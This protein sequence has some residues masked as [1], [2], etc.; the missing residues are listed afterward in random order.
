MIKQGKRASVITVEPFGEL[1]GER[2][3]LYTLRNRSGM[4]VRATN[5]GAT[6]IAIEVANRY[7][8]F[9]DVVLGF[10]SLDGYQNNNWYCGATIGRCAGRISNAHF[11]LDGK[12]YSLTANAGSAHLHGGNQGFDKVAWQADAFESDSDRV[13]RLRYVSPSGAEGYPGTLAVQVVYTLTEMNELLVDLFATTDQPTPVNMTHH[14]YFNLAGAELHDTLDHQL[15]INAELFLPIDQA[16]IPT[17][18]MRNVRNTPFDFRRARRIGSSI[19]AADEQV[20]HAQ[21]YDHD[22]VLRDTGAARLY[23]ADSGRVLDI[24]T[25]QPSLHIYT[26]NYLNG[27][28]LGKNQVPY[29]RRSGIALEAQHFPDS[30]NH[31]E[32]PSIILR[33][34]Q[35]YHMRTVYRFSVTDL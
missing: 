13:V 4:E 5:Y 26:G 27:E 24:F 10:D 8:R 3:D 32:F 9:E 6:I 22:F 28:P 25:T 31:P 7:G 34:G 15:Q 19:E 20:Q 2:I 14:G 29:R 21:G 18:E 17:G 12:S 30:P 23:D 35:Q 16:L 33:P 11:S 1:A